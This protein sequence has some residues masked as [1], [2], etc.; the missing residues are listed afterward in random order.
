MVE[1]LPRLEQLPHDYRELRRFLRA[2]ETSLGPTA[3][4]EELLTVALGQIAEE[5]QEFVLGRLRSNYP[6]AKLTYLRCLRMDELDDDSPSFSVHDSTRSDAYVRR[7]EPYEARRSPPPR[8]ATRQDPSAIRKNTGYPRQTGRDVLASSSTRPNRQRSSINYVQRQPTPFVP[9]PSHQ[10]SPSPLIPPIAHR[11]SQA[12][13][14]VNHNPA[15]RTIVPASTEACFFCGSSEHM[16][17]QCP[18]FAAAR[19]QDP[20]RGKR[21]PACNSPGLCPPDCRR[22]LFSSRSKHRYLELNHGG[23]SY[24]LRDDHA[25]PRWYRKELLV[26]VL[27]NPSC[28]T[29]AHVAHEAV[30]AT[31]NASPSTANQAQSLTPAHSV[32]AAAP[33]SSPGT[34]ASAKPTQATPEPTPVTSAPPPPPE[35]SVSTPLPMPLRRPPVTHSGT[36]SCLHARTHRFPA[37]PFRPGHTRALTTIDGVRCEAVIDT[38]ADLS[39]ISASLLRPSH[40]YRPW[41][42][43]DGSV[44][45]VGDNALSI[46]GRTGLEVCLGPLK[47][48][49]PFVVVVG[50]NFAALFG[51]DFLYAHDIS[52]SLAQHALVFEGLEGQALGD[53]PVHL[54]AGW[55]LAPVHFV[56]H[57]AICQTTLV[58]SDKRVQHDSDLIAGVPHMKASRATRG[59][60]APAPKS[61]ESK[62]YVKV[63][64]GLLPCLPSPN[65]CLS[66]TELGELRSL[67]EEFKDRFNGGTEPLPATTLLRARLDTRDTPPVSCPP[68][69]LSPAMR[70]V[71]RAAVAELDAQ[72]I[73]EPG[74]GCWS[75]PIVMVRKASGAWRLCCDYREINKHVVIPQQPLPRPDDI[76]ASFNGKRYFSVLDMCSGFYQIEI[77]EEDRP[78]TAL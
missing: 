61:E 67:L 72:G 23:F 7:Q 8:G 69:R 75:A 27:G 66:Q 17:R 42:S 58:P 76:L 31:T 64:G 57:S 60:D 9:P 59:T 35:S 63:P 45:G 46:F 4:S 22:R 51:V 26:G 6:D 78:K 36:A 34:P 53:R 44:T 18:Q 43:E 5:L 14:A 48:Q 68:R 20:E 54:C 73:M 71:V 12:P 38:G 2:V 40:T 74:T 16:L 33:P 30:P 10:T 3:T 15:S 56:R 11:G 62:R 21:C 29:V 24:F 49:A 39:L 32:E 13:L 28:A 50:V 25:L 70:A 52:V 55:P 47:A 41:T 37:A 65:S 77:E 19:E 1:R